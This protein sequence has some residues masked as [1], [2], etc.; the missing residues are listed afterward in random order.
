MAEIEFS[1]KEIFT[2]SDGSFKEVFNRDYLNAS[3]R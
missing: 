3:V 2:E 1:L